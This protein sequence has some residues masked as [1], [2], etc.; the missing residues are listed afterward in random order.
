VA[1][2]AMGEAVAALHRR[3]VRVRYLGSYPRSAAPETEQPG[4][5]GGS[6]KRTAPVT[7]PV[8]G[9]AADRFAEAAAW[10]AGVRAGTMA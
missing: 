2:P 1:Q 4:V 10:L 5:N 6:G 7:E 8:N 3:C 9:Y